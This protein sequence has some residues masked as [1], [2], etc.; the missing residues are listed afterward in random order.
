MADLY[1]LNFDKFEIGYSISFYLKFF[2]V[3]IYLLATDKFDSLFLEKNTDLTLVLDISALYFLIWL[4]VTEFI[5]EKQE[6]S[7]LIG[8]IIVVLLFG[9]VSFF[10]EVITRLKGT[11]L[12]FLN[13]II[14]LIIV[15]IIF[16]AAFLFFFGDWAWGI[17]SPYEW[18]ES[19]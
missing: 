2:V 6:L 5:F 8:L 14:I 4:L 1:L 3:F 11:R 13:L 15:I 19:Y 10:I 17:V 7:K 16:S 12:A 9:S 18:F